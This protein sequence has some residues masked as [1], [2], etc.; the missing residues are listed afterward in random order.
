MS[1]KLT[2]KIIEQMIR[3]NQAGEYGAKRIYQGQIDFNSD[4]KLAP[5]LNHM[6]EQEDVHLKYFNHVMIEE[7][8]TPTLLTPFWHIGG[9]AMGAIT[10]A[11][12]PKLAHA[13]TIAVED[14]IE[15]HY[16]EQLQTLDFYEGYTPL[17]EKI[18]LFQKEEV[19]HANLA[20]QQ[21]GNDHPLSPFV[22]SIVRAITKTAI[23]LSKKI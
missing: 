21:G 15:E 4:P 16:Q 18:K 13:C 6:A 10:A 3:V 19:E 14:V 17:Q 8:I 11:L 9:Y 23:H 12:S 5:T 2:P 7:N 22:K 1:Q 20:A